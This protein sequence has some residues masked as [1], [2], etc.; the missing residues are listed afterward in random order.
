MTRNDG[1]FRVVTAK[2]TDTVLGAIAAQ[3]IKGDAAR[4]FADLITGVVLLRITMAPQLRVQGILR[5]TNGT[6]TLVAE[7]HPSRPHARRSSRYTGGSETVDVG[8][9]S[10]LR[11]MRTLHDGSLQQGMV[12]VERGS[13]AT[14]LMTYLQSSEQVSSMIAVGSGRGRVGDRVRGR[15]PR[16]S[17]SLK[18]SADRSLIMTERLEAISARSTIASAQSRFFRRLR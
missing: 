3:N 6:G 9:G 15:L 7:L 8:A 4:H 11:L 2:T 16:C 10:L 5:G 1:S 12:E 17:Y 18:W 14:G 13:V